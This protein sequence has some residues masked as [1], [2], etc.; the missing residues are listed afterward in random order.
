VCAIGAAVLAGCGYLGEPLPPLANVPARVSDLAAVQ[1]GARIIAQFT[2]ATLTTEGKPIPQPMELDLRVG[3]SEP[4]NL[5][6]WE[7]HAKAVSEAPSKDG[8]ARYE[9]LSAE[10]AGKSVVIGVRTI[11]GNGKASGWSNFVT[12]PVIPALAKPSALTAEAT[13]GGVKLLWQAPDGSFRVFRKPEGAEGYALA[14]TVTR[15]EWVD[16]DAEYGKR[17]EYLV[18]GIRDVGDNHTA[19]SDLSDVAALTPEDK[20]PPAAPAGLHATAAPASI[21]LSWEPN[22]ESDLA[23]YRIYRA[24]GGGAFEKVGDVS[25]VP[26]YSDRTVERGKQYRYAVTAVDRAGN[27][28]GR[29]PVVEASVE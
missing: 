14:A 15:R 10:W 16:A 6:E 3:P 23:S 19:E 28:S 11:A 12:V 27:E 20:F 7:S 22:S 17:I 26:A 2:V 9:I 18:Q 4:F 25:A 13:A 1:R 21:E 8:I 24:L 29:S 5:G